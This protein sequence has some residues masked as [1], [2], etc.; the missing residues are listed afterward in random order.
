M[1]D[2]MIAYVYAMIKCITVRPYRIKKR[3]AGSFG[4]PS[5]DVMCVS[6]FSYPYAS[7]Y[8]TQRLNK[9]I[10]YMHRAGLQ[11]VLFTTAPGS[12]RIL[13]YS[14]DSLPTS[15]ST[16]RTR[17]RVS[18]GLRGKKWLLPDDY[19][20]WFSTA[21]RSIEAFLKHNDAKVI[22]ATA[23]PYTNLLVGYYI[24]R[25]YSIPLIADFR[26]PWNKIDV[27]SWRT[28]GKIRCVINK[29]LEKAVLKQ[30]KNIICADNSRWFKE[31]FILWNKQIENKTLSI[32]NGYDED[33]F[34][35]ASS[36][37]SDRG[38][39]IVSWIGNVYSIKSVDYVRE[40]LRALKKRSPDV[41]DEILLEYAGP[42]SHHIRK[43]K[44]EG[45]VVVDH[46]YVSHT[47][48]LRLRFRAQVQ[49][50]VQPE[51]FKK[52]VMS[53]KIYEMIR[54]PVAILALVNEDSDVADLIR[55]TNTGIS[56]KQTNAEKFAEAILT[57]YA[58]WKNGTYDFAPDCGEIKKYSRGEQIDKLI[59]LVRNTGCD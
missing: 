13:D 52:H 53:G 48:A 25:K 11:L 35:I 32:L 18:T 37:V 6:Y 27:G 22:V 58:K 47:E 36:N 10:K 44:E 9:F 51:Y 59:R 1:C 46:G 21:V 49:L 26:D 29:E 7:D 33:D 41:F 19:V 2:D 15:V 40:G 50:F 57:Y 23:P 24:S 31:Y 30:S 55:R 56:I 39:F 45:I 34:Q 8:G 14:T 17:E 16:V 28:R 12:N 42:A 4:R 20:P 3:S 54:T 43:L 5:Y 38:K